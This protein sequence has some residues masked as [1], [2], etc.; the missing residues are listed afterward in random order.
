LQF[1]SYNFLSRH[2]QRL[3]EAGLGSRLLRIRRG[4]GGRIEQAQD[5]RSA[6]PR[7]VL[8]D[9]HVRDGRAQQWVRGECALEKRTSL[10]YHLQVVRPE[11]PV[12]SQP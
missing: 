5:L 3:K 1:P 8:H 4:A 6:E 7:A 2:Q 12:Q 10:R 9:H 11:R